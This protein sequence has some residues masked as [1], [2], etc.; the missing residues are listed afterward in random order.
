MRI[1]DYPFTEDAAGAVR[2]AGYSLESLLTRASFKAVR[3]RAMRRVAGALQGAIPESCPQSQAEHLS[4]LL[5][6]PLARVMVS[7]LGD[8]I[9]LRRYALAE[10]KLAFR[11]MQEEA[12]HEEPQ[13][14]AYQPRS[15]SGLP[16]GHRGGDQEADGGGGQGEGSEG[17]APAGG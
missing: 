1:S 6:Y 2:E 15:F 14:E 7:C 3:S 11:R 12:R 4:E 10:A 5:S 8:E 9:L 13:V 17:S 16:H